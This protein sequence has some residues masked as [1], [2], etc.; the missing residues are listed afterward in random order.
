MMSSNSLYGYKNKNNFKS[1]SS[2]IENI[3][4]SKSLLCDMLN[5]QF[6][7]H[8]LLQWQ[9]IFMAWSFSSVIIVECCRCVYVCVNL[10]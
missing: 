8:H 9:W 1:L 6:V 2:D 5:F 4:I 3:S 10:F 7:I